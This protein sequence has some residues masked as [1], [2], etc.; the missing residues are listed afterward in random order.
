MTNSLRFAIAAF[1][2]IATA[3]A[4]SA[5]TIIGLTADNALVAIDSETRRAAAPIR[6]SGADGRVVG[7]DQ[8]PQDGRLYGVTES[9]QIVTINPADGRATQVSRL[10]MPFASGGRAIVD[11]N[12]VANRLRL[13]GMNGTNLRVNVD[14]GEAVT[15]GTLKYAAGTPMADS[16]PRI[17]AG[18][19]TNSMNGA[20]QTALYTIDTL[21]R[22]LN[23]QA[24]P[25]DGVQQPRG[26]VAAA[27]PA[28]VAF[29]ILA[30]GQ[31]GNTTFLLAGGVMHSVNL[32]S[33]AASATGPVTG[34]PA[35]EVI[36]IAAMR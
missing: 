23:L 13:M 27:L 7:I 16:N 1:G 25:N 9:G 11:F 14:T 10:N 15:D 36:D 24:P 18:A 30:D 8:R 26:E 35:V 5:A 12:P 4:A 20:Q 21:A 19:Y 31:G 3:Q 2:M 6:I 34:L 28:G 32:D 17:V 33:G 22:R 29:D